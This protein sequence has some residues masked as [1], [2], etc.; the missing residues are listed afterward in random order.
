MSTIKRVEVAS[1]ILCSSLFSHSPSSLLPNHPQIVENTNL[2]DSWRQLGLEM[3][4]TIA[5]T[6][7]AMLRKMSQYIPLISK[8]R[9][10]FLPIPCRSIASCQSQLTGCLWLVELG[11]IV[12]LWAVYGWWSYD[13]S[14][15]NGK[16]AQS[17]QN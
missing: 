1:H 3:I 17:L 8:S 4:V 16:S 10:P 11:C 12:G 15:G 5:E 2:L 9:G 7:P 14:L 6:A 13:A